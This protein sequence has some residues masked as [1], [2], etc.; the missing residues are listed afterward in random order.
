MSLHCSPIPLPG[1][2]GSLLVLDIIIRAGQPTCTRVKTDWNARHRGVAAPLGPVPLAPKTKAR[3]APS[4]RVSYNN[5][6]I[7]G[8]RHDCNLTIFLATCKDASKVPILWLLSLPTCSTTSGTLP[9]TLVGGHQSRPRSAQFEFIDY[10]SY[11][12][13]TYVGTC[14]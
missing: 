13:K 9:P 7:A 3:A 12:K 1:R 6:P 14:V 8:L 4:T 5:L 11:S 10:N 2:E